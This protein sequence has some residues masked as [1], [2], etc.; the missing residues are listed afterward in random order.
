LYENWATNC[1]V[2]QYGTGFYKILY[3]MASIDIVSNPKTGASSYKNNKLSKVMGTKH[4]KHNL[5]VP[6]I[7]LSDQVVA[8]SVLHYLRFG[9]N[10]SFIKKNR[11][12]ELKLF[13]V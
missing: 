6:I 8:H 10:H 3:R 12:V 7:N 2:D 13:T 11:H 5:S 9:L 4:R 1:I